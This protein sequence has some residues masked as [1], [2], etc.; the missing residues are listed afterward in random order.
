VL[1]IS[2]R[3]NTTVLVTGLAK[4][5]T[6]ERLTSFFEN[7]SKGVTCRKSVHLSLSRTSFR[8]QP[9]FGLGLT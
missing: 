6:V 3:E 5:T 9:R 2:D 8:R 4:G 7:V 1:M